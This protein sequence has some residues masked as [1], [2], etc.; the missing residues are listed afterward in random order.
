MGC[1]MRLSEYD[2]SYER[3]GMG[4]I[5]FFDEHFDRTVI[6]LDLDLDSCAD[7]IDLML[8]VAALEEA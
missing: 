1:A 5:R 4:L 7:T 6:E 8:H 3:I 2:L